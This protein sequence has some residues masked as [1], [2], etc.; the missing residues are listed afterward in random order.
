MVGFRLIMGFRESLGFCLFVG[1][2]WMYC[3][4]SFLSDGCLIG[5][6]LCLGLLWTGWC[7]C[8]HLFCSWMSGLY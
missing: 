2:I 8:D 1:W 7:C 3:V 5:C 6:V 4:D